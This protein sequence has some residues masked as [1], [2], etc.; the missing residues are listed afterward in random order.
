MATYFE[1]G[2][3]K[4]VTGS[5]HQMGREAAAQALS[6]LV[7]F[8]PTLA[9]V[10]A[11][12]DLDLEAVNLGVREVMGKCPLI[13]TSTAGE[14]ADG[15][16]RGGV[17]VAVVASPHVKVR[18]GMGRGV[19]RDYRAA[20]RQ[21]LEQAGVCEYFNPE[22]PMHQ[23]LHM[24]APGPAGA[25]PVLLIVFSPGTTRTHISLSHDIHTFL[26][27]SSA[28]RIPIFGGSS[29]DYTLWAVNYQMVNDTVSE[30]SVA[31]AFLESEVLFGM[32]MEHGF[33]PTT[34]RA[35]ITSASGHI[36]RELDG[37]PAAEVCAELLEVPLEKLRAGDV[38]LKRFPFGATDLYGNTILHVAEKVLDNDSVQFGPIMRSDQVI[39]LMEGKEEEIERAGISAYM[40]ALR[41]GGLRKPCLAMMFS[42]SLRLENSG[43]RKEI[44]VIRRR[45]G[46]PVCGFYTFGEKGLSDDGLP[47]YS[48]QSVSMLV[49][50]D[51]LNPVASLIHEGKRAY[52]DFSARLKR[53]ALELEAV[54]RINR[55]VQEARD[56]ETLLEDLTGEL[57]ELFPRAHTAFYL[58]ERDPEKLMLATASDSEVFANR[59]SATVDEADMKFISMESRG[60]R[61]GY[62]VLR[63]KQGL[64]GHDNDDMALAYTV[65]QLAASGLHRIELDDQLGVRLQQLEILNQLGYELSRPA[66]TGTQSQNVIRRIREV[67]NLSFAS[68]WL[69][70]STHRLLVKEAL[71]VAP[72]YSI[73]EVER[74]NDETIAKWQIEQQRPLWHPQGTDV[75]C[76][77]RLMEPFNYSFASLPF[78]NQ[79]QLCGIL[80]LYSDR[81]YRWSYQNEPLL[82]NMEFLKTLSNQIAIFIENR[83]LQK[84]ATFYREMHHRVKNNLQ[85]IA[86][87][88]RMQLR[89]L[90][91]VPAEQAL[92]DSI[93]RIMSIALVHETL[94][95]GEIGMVDLGRLLG[96]IS[97]LPDAGTE[98]RPVITL[99]LSGPSVMIPSKEATSV[100]LVINEL[101][102]NAFQHGLRGRGEGRIAIK[103]EESDGMISLCI[104]DDGPG[105]PEGFDVER[106]SNLGL[107][108]VCTLVK[109]EL[110]GSFQLDGSKGT[111]AR[112]DFPYPEGYYHLE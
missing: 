92:S 108:I 48:N 72:G 31:L 39:T 69:V 56:V 94:S 40:K 97:R 41:Q 51:E 32:G 12:S 29:S 83:T 103:V 49:F 104:E 86:S 1:C 11:C 71:D 15:F 2:V 82:E 3:G 30:D 8:S 112:I 25:S 95:Q 45:L 81:S 46:V 65:A 23:T 98:K 14:I 38:V 76:P 27:T 47:V 90:D 67:L 61:F 79:R 21:A 42:C 106:N 24:N 18:V 33:S 111:R 70:N 59:I 50:S 63:N 88:L 53:K 107:T 17:V 66:D 93:S 16:V 85:N 37:R 89:R 28:N 55:I 78:H 100:A 87:L 62:L 110:K 77:M 105:L 52:R 10:F 9:I 101:L 22:H 73:G 91:R 35:L 20:V 60:R 36:V 43:G 5:S 19:N 84:H 26:R 57:L 68:L 34:K 13:G 4:A 6:Q 64:R 7:K 102:Q 54:S 58:P 99:D 109:E 96:S 44:A 74:E 80:N 75:S